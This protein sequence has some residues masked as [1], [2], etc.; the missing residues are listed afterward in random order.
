MSSHVMGCMVQVKVAQIEMRTHARH[1]SDQAYG[2]QAAFTLPFLHS[3]TVATS[4]RTAG[5]AK[6]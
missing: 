2:E 1:M 6:S 5:D 3:I 4:M